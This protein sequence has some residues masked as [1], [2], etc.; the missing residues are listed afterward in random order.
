QL[1]IAQVCLQRWSANTMEGRRP[2]M[3]HEDAQG[4]RSLWSYSRLADTSNR[5]ANGLRKMGIRKGDRVVLIMSQRPEAAAAALA[6]FASGAILVPLSPL[7][8]ID[9]LNLRL[10]DAEASLVIADASAAPDLT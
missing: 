6:V 7:L 1:N 10:R 8:G 5:L 2:A 9:G 4:L 3:Q